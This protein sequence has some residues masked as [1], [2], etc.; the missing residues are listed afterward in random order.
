MTSSK[1]WNPSPSPP[2]P[3]CESNSMLLRNLHHQADVMRFMVSFHSMS[4][5]WLRD[6][7]S[8]ISLSSITGC[9]TEEGGFKATSELG[10]GPFKT[11]GTW[12]PGSV[13]GGEGEQYEEEDDDGDDGE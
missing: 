10:G 1:T 4:C 13:I 6:W 7:I 8:A 11:V 3:L 2:T 9:N 5:C 12:S